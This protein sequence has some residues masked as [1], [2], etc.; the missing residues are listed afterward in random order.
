MT[1]DGMANQHIRVLFCL[2]YTYHAFRIDI[3]PR[4]DQ[5][6]DHIPVASVCSY[7]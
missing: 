2:S 4:F 3:G 1:Y 5:H 7:P 6:L